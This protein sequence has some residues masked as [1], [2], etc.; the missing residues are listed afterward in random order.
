VLKV[1]AASM[2]IP[3]RSPKPRNIT[4]EI[5]LIYIAFFIHHYTSCRW[6]QSK[7]LKLHMLASIAPLCNIPMVHLLQYY[8]LRYIFCLL[9][10]QPWL[11]WKLLQ[12][13]QSG[14]VRY[15]HNARLDY[16]LHCMGRHGLRH[17]HVSGSLKALHTTLSLYNV[18]APGHHLQ[19]LR[20]RGVSVWFIIK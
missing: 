15:R 16:P 6:S 1:H 3:C 4:Q 13:R 10:L 17:T 11:D 18:F 8:V 5:N 20:L 19:T 14:Q 2:H 7:Q 9:Y 12:W